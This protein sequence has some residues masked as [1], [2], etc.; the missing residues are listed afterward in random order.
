MLNIK[1]ASLI[2]SAQYFISSLPKCLSIIGS[3]Y[4]HVGR[5]GM[6]TFLHSEKKDEYY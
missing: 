5:R 1:K 3:V 4:K 2:N 6:N